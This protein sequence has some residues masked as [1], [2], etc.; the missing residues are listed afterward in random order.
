MASA[1]GYPTKPIRLLVGVAPGGGTD[2]AARLIGQKLNEAWGQPVVI[3]NRTGA[4]GLIAMELVAKSPPDGYTYIVFNIAHL[5]SASLSRRAGFDTEKAFAPVSLIA[6]G[7]LM[8][9]VHPSVPGGTLSEFIAHAKS[10]PGKLAY[11]S[12]GPASV[13]QL[14]MELLKREARI[15]L[16]HVPYKGTGPG[17]VDLLAGQVQASLTNILALHPHV[18]AGRLKGLAVANPK[19]SA[20]AE[21]V[22]TF[23]EVGY[24]KVDVNVWQGIMGPAGT[25][26]AVQE[27]LARAIT[28]AIRSPDTV[29]RLAAQGAEP[30]GTSPREFAAFLK[31]ERDK[32]LTLAAEAKITVD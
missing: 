2:F 9:A 12:G 19:R 16:L 13:Q 32:W 24:P 4:T 22:P 23:A 7:T 1:A 29:A 15:D 20:L 3:D 11:A 21:E 14:A 17:L 5:M 18:K 26:P 30:A 6:I 10:H 25:P 27:K 31:S 28:E 8:L